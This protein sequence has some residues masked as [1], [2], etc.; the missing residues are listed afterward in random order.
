M[1]YWTPAALNVVLLSVNVIFD[2][3]SG[4]LLIHTSIF[5]CVRV[6]HV[7]L[8]S[9]TAVFHRNGTL[10]LL[11]SSILRSATAGAFFRLH[12][13]KPFTQTYCFSDENARWLAES[14]CYFVVYI[15]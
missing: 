9:E 2:V 13:C 7:C 6:I 5:I 11:W 1:M 4:T 14:G 10:V 3:V 15:F 12:I 8:L